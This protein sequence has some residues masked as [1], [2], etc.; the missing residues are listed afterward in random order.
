MERADR[1]VKPRNT[2]KTRKNCCTGVI[3][4]GVDR[5]DSGGAGNPPRGAVAGC[6]TA[7]KPRY[8]AFRVTETFFA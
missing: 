5:P 8:A 7:E 2:R 4:G 3:P 6:G 1:T